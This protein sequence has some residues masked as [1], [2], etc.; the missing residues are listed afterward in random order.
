[1]RFI[2]LLS[3]SI[4]L[5][6]ENKKAFYCW[7]ESNPSGAEV[8]E[9]GDRKGKTPLI[10][11]HLANGPHKFSLRLKGYERQELELKVPNEGT[12]ITVELVQ[13]PKYLIFESTPVGASIKHGSQNLGVTPLIYEKASIGEGEQEFIAL[14]KGFAVSKFTLNIGG[15][16]VSKSV[17]LVSNLGAIRLVVLPYNA[18][19]YINNKLMSPLKE[20]KDLQSKAKTYNGLPAG[21]Y[22]IKL[23]IEGEDSIPISLKVQASEVSEKALRMWFPNEHIRLI[24]DTRFDAM[25][26]SDNENEKVVLLKDMKIK[27]IPKSEIR[28]ILQISTDAAKKLVKKD[29]IFRKMNK[30][31]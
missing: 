5:N 19:V 17:E 28:K 31:K 10:V 26:L 20:G 12:K 21:K 30:K 14:L 8:Y 4:L 13:D 11:Q 23:R 2:L 25:V 3:L 15:G 7:I 22:K 6:A 29:R 27:K 18:Q 16:A 9:K 1:M 24:N